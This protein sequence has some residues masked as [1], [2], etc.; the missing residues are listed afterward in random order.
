MF[1]LAPSAWKMHGWRN[2]HGDIFFLLLCWVS[3]SNLNC[4]VTARLDFFFFSAAFGYCATSFH[5]L[6]MCCWSVF[7]HPFLFFL[8]NSEPSFLSPFNEGKQGRLFEWG[9]GFV[10]G[11]G[12]CWK[13]SEGVML[14]LFSFPCVRACVCAVSF[15]WLSVFSVILVFPRLLPPGNAQCN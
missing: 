2:R 9:F 4:L 6:Y 8:K 14:F 12:S 7:F 11:E 1:S 3:A 13:K 10:E 5:P 15:P